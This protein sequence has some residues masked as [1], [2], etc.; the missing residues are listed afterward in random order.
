MLYVLLGLD[1]SIDCPESG[2]LTSISLQSCQYIHHSPPHVYS[3]VNPHTIENTRTLIM[4]ERRIHIIRPN[5]IHAQLLHQRRIP[6]TSRRI[7]ERIAIA[8]AIRVLTTGLVVD[9]NDHEPFAGLGVDEFL[10]SHDDG[11]D[12]QRGGGRQSEGGGGESLQMRC[13]AGIRLVAWWWLEEYSRTSCCAPDR[14]DNQSFL[15]ASTFS[16]ERVNRP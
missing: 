15:I 10:V 1:R 9:A 12:G 11:V 4:I 7:A 5:G 3:H 8:C 14:Q 6:Q 13:L 2:E 16:N